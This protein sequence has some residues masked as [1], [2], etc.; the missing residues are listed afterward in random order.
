MIDIRGGAIA[1]TAACESPYCY[2]R[3]RPR[4]AS[5]IDI[6]RFM[7]AAQCCCRFAA[8]LRGTSCSRLLPSLCNSPPISNT[9]RLSTSPS[10]VT[11]KSDPLSQNSR[12]FNQKSQPYS[13]ITPPPTSDATGAGSIH[14]PSHES[15][16]RRLMVMYDAIRPTCVGRCVHA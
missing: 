12:R 3:R 13:P 16:T 5:V 11:A 15:A 10:H 1:C 7:T 9:P 4:C 14:V 6:E 2:L 8:L